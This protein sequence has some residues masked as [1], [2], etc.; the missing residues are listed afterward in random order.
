VRWIRSVATLAALAMALL[1]G[2]EDAD[3]RFAHGLSLGSRGSRTFMLPPVT[4]AAANTAVALDSP[5]TAQVGRLAYPG[6]SL[7]GLFNRPGLI[8]GFAAGFLGAGLLGLLFGHG[9]FG[10]LG[11]AAS[12][13]GLMFQLALLGMLGR[14]IWTWWHG[15]NTPAFADLSPRQLADAYVRPR[16]ESLPDID[17]PAFAHLEIT[18]SDHDCFERLLS[19]IEAAY[20]REDL[21]ALRARVTPQMMGYFSKNLARNAGRGVINVVSDVK[22]IKGDLAEAW[23]E[24]DIDYA[25]VAMRFSLIDRTVERASGRIVDGSA[26][27]AI[28][29]TQVWTFSRAHGHSWLLSA[30][31]QGS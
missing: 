31:Q 20:G 26:V 14:L 18:A 30:I 21:D 28:E 10:G 23:R 24:G 11:G 17:S 12:F 13:L 5:M 27:T 4:A 29:A 25:A 3:A 9:L 22:L 7:G 8:G 19:E 15:G 2:A 6:G 1:M 16:N